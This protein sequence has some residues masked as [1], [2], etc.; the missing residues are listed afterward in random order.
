MLNPKKHENGTPILRHKLEY[1][2]TSRRGFQ[3]TLRVSV[4]QFPMALSW[5]S[6]SHKMQVNNTIQFSSED[7]CTIYSLF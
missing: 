5:A 6:T 2:A 4:T 7:E 1:Q 3:Q